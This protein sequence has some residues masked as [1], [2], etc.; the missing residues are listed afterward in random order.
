M[1]PTCP[2]P[3]GGAHW[4]PRPQPTS[5]SWCSRV[6]C[7]FQGLRTRRAAPNRI[8]THQKIAGSTA[9]RSRLRSLWR[10]WPCIWPPGTR[11]IPARYR[12]RASPSTMFLSGSTSPHITIHPP[13]EAS[14]RPSRSHRHDH[15][16]PTRHHSRHRGRRMA[17]NFRRR[18]LP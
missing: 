14:R 13:I 4:G 16:H 8:R 7:V 12:A 10:Q 9:H 5:D 15:Q 3:A 18:P 17:R 2:L 11:S 1:L 6:R